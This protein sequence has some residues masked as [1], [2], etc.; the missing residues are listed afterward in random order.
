[1]KYTLFSYYIL[2]KTKQNKTKQSGKK[3]KADS[4]DFHPKIDCIYFFQ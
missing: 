2:V 1:M 3:K 4:N